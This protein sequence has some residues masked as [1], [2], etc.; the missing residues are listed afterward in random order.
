MSS[1]NTAT[2]DSNQHNDSDAISD[3]DSTGSQTNAVEQTVQEN[4]MPNI[5]KY[6]HTG[7]GPQPV[8]NCGICCVTKV[9]VPGLPGHSKDDGDNGDD[10]KFEDA[11]ILACGHV[12]GSDCFS[13]W[14][15]V[16]G[17][18]TR[19]PVCRERAYPED[20]ITQEWEDD[21]DAWAGDSEG[22]EE[23]S[24]DADEEEEPVG[25]AYTRSPTP[26]ILSYL[27][28]GWAYVGMTT[29]RSSR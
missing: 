15:R 12:F 18:N 17:I 29:R 13:Q 25:G 11:A 21:S 22:S 6:L 2:N 20:A 19:C 24:G 10:A 23:E 7:E 8:V 26:A 4:Y 1:P 27:P 28:G 9:V 3:S 16:E 14:A 5:A